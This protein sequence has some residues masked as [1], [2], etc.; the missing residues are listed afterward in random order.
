MTT[1]DDR[2][3]E[4]LDAVVARDLATVARLGGLPPALPA[5]WVVTR[6]GG[7]P[8]AYVR[9]FLGDPVQ[10]AFWSPTSP[11]G[12]DRLKV[13]FRDDA[14]VKLEGEWPELDPAA[15]SVLGPP[16]RRFEDRHEDVWASV[17]VAL[18]RQEPG[19][20]FTAL[21]VFAPTTPDEYGRD[22]AAHEEYREWD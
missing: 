4:L 3:T 6:L 22:L 14:V 11:A 1:D 20:R 5:E 8:E 21:S 7:D 19:G 13:W 16:E 17:G 12:F 9:F 18:T 10:E 15:D 2:A